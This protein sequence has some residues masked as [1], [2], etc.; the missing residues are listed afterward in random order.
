VFTMALLSLIPLCKIISDVTKSLSKY[1]SKNFGILMMT[2]LGNLPDLI[3]MG[4]FFSKGHSEIVHKM[5]IENLVS[6][7][8]LL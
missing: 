6:T 3:M 5:I 8:L 1:T 7:P 4:P 2:I